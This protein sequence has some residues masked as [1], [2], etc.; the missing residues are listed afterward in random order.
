M[1]G[2]GGTCHKRRHFQIMC[3]SNVSVVESTD[4]AAF[5]GAVQDSVDT[6]PWVIIQYMEI[7]EIQD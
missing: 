7:L 4:E 1:P 6:T 5:M 2:Q 3:R